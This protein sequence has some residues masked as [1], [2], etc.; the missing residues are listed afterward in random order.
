MV[1]FTSTMIC[2]FIWYLLHIMYLLTKFASAHCYA[3]LLV[4]EDITI[5]LYPI[6][7][8]FFFRKMLPTWSFI[9]DVHQIVDSQLNSRYS[10]FGKHFRWWC[11]L[12]RYMIKISNKM[13]VATGSP[14]N[15]IPRIKSLIMRD[16]KCWFRRRGGLNKTSKSHIVLL[17]LGVI[18]AGNNKPVRL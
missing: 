13:S 16:H 17:Y 9:L 4:F 1:I 3:F 11:N 8:V 10:S 5:N 6:S 14:K 7:S 12:G 15:V 2:R 18:N